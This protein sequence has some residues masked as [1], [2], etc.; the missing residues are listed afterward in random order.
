MISK[1]TYNKT[2]WIDLEA[3]TKDEVLSLVG[4]YDIPLLVV[5]NLLEP[6]VRSK[7][8]KYD[9]LIYLTLH[10]PNMKG[11][12]NKGI[13]QEIDFVV[14]RDF[15]ITT[16]YEMIDPLHE[17]SKIFET[18]SILNKSKDMGE[19]AG[20]LFYYLIKELYKNLHLELDD[21]NKYLL[22][23]ERKIFEGKEGEVVEEISAVNRKL[24]D[25]KQSIRFHREILK[26]FEFAGKEFF[27]NEFSYYLGAIVGEYNKIQNI[28]DGHKEILNDL[29]DTNDSLL[30][31]K[32]NQT[33]KVLTVMNFIMLPLALITGI[34]G[35]NSDIIFI[36]NLSDF[37]LVLG[38]MALIGA[39]MYLFFKHKKW[40]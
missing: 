22:K 38:S 39:L 7:I 36:R 30:T 26:S 33:M 4:E 20:F 12:K 18:N 14:G 6:T 1:Y 34:F 28:L 29:K 27:G 17:F 11:G 16:H 19:H 37:F 9:N 21:L 13:E 3:P 35:M 31:N 24:L 5:D 40:I 25:F 10:F 32:T 15:I 23:I 2:T 8:D